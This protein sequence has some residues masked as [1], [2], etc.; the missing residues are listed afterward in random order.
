MNTSNEIYQRALC[1]LL[2]EI[3]DGPPGNEA[4][5]LNPGD[6]GLWLNRLFCFGAAEY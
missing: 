3:F 4:Y 2:S 1:K 6:P 5:L